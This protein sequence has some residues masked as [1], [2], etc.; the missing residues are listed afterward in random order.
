MNRKLM[1]WIPAGILGVITII[2][3][4]IAINIATLNLPCWVQQN[5]NWAWLAIAILG[6]IA[7]ILVFV[8]FFLNT[9]SSPALYE[10]ELNDI[11]TKVS[12][13]VTTASHYPNDKVDWSSTL[14]SWKLYARTLV[15]TYNKYKGRRDRKSKYIV[16]TSIEL[17][18]NLT[19]AAKKICLIL[20]RKDVFIEIAK[21][22]YNIVY[23]YKQKKWLNVAGLAYEI[24]R[25]YHE[26]EKHEESYE[27]IDP[28]KTCLRKDGLHG[29]WVKFYK[30]DPNESTVVDKHTD[31]AT[32]S[33]LYQ[34][35]VWTSKV[36]DLEGLNASNDDMAR[37]YFDKAL[38]LADMLPDKIL[39]SWIKIHIGDLEDR[40]NLPTAK[41]RYEE[42]LNSATS[43][44]SVEFIDLS[45]TC[46]NKLGRLAF[47]DTDE[48]YS[49]AVNLYNEQLKLAGD[50]GR[51]DFEV[52]AHEG[53]AKIFFQGNPQNLREAYKHA[54]KAWNINKEFR[55]AGTEVVESN[56][57]VSLIIGITDSLMLNAPLHQNIAPDS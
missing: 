3:M 18:E 25:V 50:N 26:L 1:L 44:N 49:K 39:F 33:Q 28:L 56:E 40:N 37:K 34:V 32:Q 20:N 27:W 38:A 24:S 48:D 11:K 53:L 23:F 14:D 42:A 22:A 7:I 17:L 5:S 19:N 12:K 15:D 30:E 10:N 55:N 57:L 21:S 2:L 9:D 45:L 13:V 41:E 47:V 16:Q 6:P 4:P 29:Y 51:R 43:S 8:P 35:L 46:K 36:Y 54:Q 52:L 31:T